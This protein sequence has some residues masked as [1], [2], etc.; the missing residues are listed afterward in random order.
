MSDGRSGMALFPASFDP[1]TNG[2]LDLIR[3]ARRIFP[4]V[5]VAVATNVDKRG[6]FSVDERIELVPLAH[7][8]GDAQGTT[9]RLR[10]HLRCQR[11]AGIELAAGDDDVGALIAD[12]V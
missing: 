12:Q 10:L 3:R 9:A 5:V 6:T 8:A 2:H 4:E 1:V 7:V 11:V